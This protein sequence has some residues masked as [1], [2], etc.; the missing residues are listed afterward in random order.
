MLALQMSASSSSS[1]LLHKA[2]EVGDVATVRRLVE[3][4][5][6]D[7]NH[8]VDSSEWTLL[9]CAATHG[10]VEVGK[11]TL[12]AIFGS[13]GS[14]N[15][16]Q[17]TPLHWA[18]RHGHGEVIK[19]LLDH[20]A[21]A[22]AVGTYEWT[23][24]HCAATNGQTRAVIKLVEYGGADINVQDSAGSTPLH[25]AA[26]HGGREVVRYLMVRG[27]NLTFEDNYGKKA[28]DVAKTAGIREFL[29]ERMGLV[30]AYASSLILVRAV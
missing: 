14:S 9:H 10:M 2:A 24:L 15:R 1:G 13:S 3:E 6:A 8:A 28:V 5:G 12:G 16:G 22:N 26:R 18:V 30:S 25:C 21:N 23:P 19:Y 29:Q 17:W 20:G 7:V 27:A 11:H 4:E